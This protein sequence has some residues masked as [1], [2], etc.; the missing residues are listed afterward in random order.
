MADNE[1]VLALDIFAR[2][3][4]RAILIAVDNATSDYSIYEIDAHPEAVAI[5]G[6]IAAIECEIEGAGETPVAIETTGSRTL[7][8]PDLQRWLD[9]RA[10]GRRFRAPSPIVEAL[11]RQHAPDWAE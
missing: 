1:F 9:E 8:S 4:K 6:I 2:P 11:I 7:S 10:I 3:G 5:S